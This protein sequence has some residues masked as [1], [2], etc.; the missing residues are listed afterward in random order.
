MRSSVAVR[1]AKPP[2]RDRFSPYRMIRLSIPRFHFAAAIPTGGPPSAGRERCSKRSCGLCSLYLSIPI[3]INSSDFLPKGLMRGST[4]RLGTVENIAHDGSLLV[5]SAFAPA[6]G[7]DV[8]DRRNRVLGRV[9]RVFGPVKEPFTSVRAAV[10]A[11]PSLI[12]ADVF[13]GEGKHA[14]EED[15]RG[16]RSH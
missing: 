8:L 7:A 13:V 16:R 6:H 15:R 9:A 11:S 2:M 10:P 5:R 1:G 14:H 4:R 3:P 12:G